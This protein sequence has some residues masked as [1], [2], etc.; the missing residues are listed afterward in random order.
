MFAKQEGEEVETLGDLPEPVSE[1]N[2]MPS[3][4]ITY[5]QIE[6]VASDEREPA[7]E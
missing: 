5:E 2:N 4:L 3:E 1:S 6:G 7:G